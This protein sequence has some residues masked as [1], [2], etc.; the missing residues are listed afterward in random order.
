[1][2]KLIVCYGSAEQIDFAYGSNLTT[3]E[4]TILPF[5]LRLEAH[6]PF[7]KV[8]VNGRKSKLHK[9]GSILSHK[10]GFSQRFRKNYKFNPSLHNFYTRRPT[11]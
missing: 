11:I 7:D 10:R 1:M 8:K 4:I 3:N 9:A 6:T 5:I 2:N